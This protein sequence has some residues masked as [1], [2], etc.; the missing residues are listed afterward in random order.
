MMVV[1]HRSFG[2]PE[3]REIALVLQA[4]DIEHA[5]E[6]GIVGWRVV[7]PAHEEARAR[8]QWRLYK[9]ENRARPPRRMEAEPRPGAL[10]G[11]LAWAFV[12]M[13]FF[14]FQSNDGFGVDWSAAGHIDVAAVRAGEWWRTITALTLHGD[15]AHLFVNIGVGAIFGALLAREIGAGYAW[16]LILI[17]GAAGNLMNVFVQR[18]GHLSLGA[19]TAVFAALGLL[20]A[21]LWTARRMLLHSWATRA[22]PVVGAII[23]LAWL[24]TGTERTDIVAHLTGFIAGF[25][26]GA[27]VGRS[28]RRPG[29]KSGRQWLSAAATLLLLVVAWQFA[30]RAAGFDPGPL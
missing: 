4:M 6:R 25:A 16:L 8:E 29:T 12:L 1:L 11:A 13:I 7:V 10:A 30:L 18:P 9:L 19:S 28:P 20:A 3:C 22:S 21:Y 23:L 24:G 27:L 17:G 15:R 14:S 2:Q 5:I 26:I